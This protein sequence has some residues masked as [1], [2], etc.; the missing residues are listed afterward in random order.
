MDISLAQDWSH[1]PSKTSQ[2]P[3]DRL[4]TN[5]LHPQPWTRRVKYSCLVRTPPKMLERMLLK[6]ARCLQGQFPNRRP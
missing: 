5:G 2:L 3:S 1:S 6:I 4:T